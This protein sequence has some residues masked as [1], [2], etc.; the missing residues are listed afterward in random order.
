MQCGVDKNTCQEGADTDASARPGKC[1][2]HKSAAN[3]TEDHA[4]KDLGINMDDA[5]SDTA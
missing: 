4:T 5:D 1:M 2:I 3:N